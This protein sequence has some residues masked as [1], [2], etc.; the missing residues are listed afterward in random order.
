MGTGRS[1]ETKW[2][3]DSTRESMGRDGRGW[4]RVLVLRVERR[5]VVD[6]VVILPVTP[7][8]SESDGL[9]SKGEI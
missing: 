5:R 7:P 8:L 4:V 6:R 3:G 1:H 9:W 2:V